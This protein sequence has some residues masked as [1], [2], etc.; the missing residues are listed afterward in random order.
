VSDSLLAWLDASAGWLVLFGVV[1]LASILAVVLAVP[2]VVLRMP[3]D[4]FV[5]PRREPAYRGYRHPALGL[6]VVALKNLLGLVLVV[7]GLLLLFTPGQGLLTIVLGLALLNFPG[8]YRLERWVVTRRGVLG[9]LNWLRRRYGRS[10]L[11]A[12]PVAEDEH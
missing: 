6:V 9:A 7:I 2:A 4:Y 12:P 11:H 1:S 3:E 10:P 8:K 5:H